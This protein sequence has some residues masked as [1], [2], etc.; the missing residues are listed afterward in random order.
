VPRLSETPGQTRFV[1]P[2]LGEHTVEVLRDLGY[3]D[4]RQRDL[5]SRGVIA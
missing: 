3:D 4:D 2:R 1:G 5:R